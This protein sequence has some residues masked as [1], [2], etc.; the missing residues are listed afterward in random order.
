[1][2]ERFLVTS[3]FGFDSSAVGLWWSLATGGTIV[4]P[5]DDE[6]H[7]VD[8]LLATIEARDVSHLLM[9]PSL[10]EALMHRSPDRMGGVRVAIVAGE[11]CPASLVRRHHEVLPGVDLVNEYGPTEATVWSTAHRVRP[12]DDPVPIGRPIPGTTVRVAGEHG[13]ALPH[14]VVGE[15]LVSGPGVTA[16][17]VGDAAAT[18]AAFV[19]LDEQRWYRTGD[20]AIVSDGNVRFVGRVD[21]Q[22]N[23]GGV[24]VEPAEI[25]N[26]LR[27]VTTIDDAIVVA[28]GRPARLVAHVVA[29]DGADVDEAT[30]RAVLGERLAPGAVP[31]R[32]IGH[33]RLPRTPNGK[34]D[35]AAAARLAIPGRVPDAMGEVVDPSQLPEP[36]ASVIWAWNEVFDVAVGPNTDF[37]AIGGDSLSAVMLVT[38]LG[39]RLERDVAVATVVRGRTPLGMADLLDDPDR[40]ASSVV[41][42][43]WFRR[44]PGEDGPV[45]VM[46]PSWDDVFGYQQL[47]RAMPDEVD[48]VAFG[49]DDRRS[50]T[51]V[52]RYV[53]LV[54]S[55]L[56]ELRS[57]RPI[58]VVG[59]SI[60]GVVAMELAAQLEHR[61]DGVVAVGLVDTFF[62]GEERHLW[63]NRWWKYRS[64]VTPRALPEWRTEIGKVVRSRLQRLRGRFRS[65]H[66]TSV[67]PGDAAGDAGAADGVD[68]AEVA[69][70]GAI[71]ADAFAHEPSR[72]DTPVVF[73]AAS[74]T[75]PA[76]THR[77]WQTVADDLTVVPVQGRHRGFESVMG[78]ERVGRL[79]DGLRPY[80]RR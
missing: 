15:L 7:D 56:D 32:V 48:V 64:L 9:V 62:P 73:F 31:Q 30:V 59:W 55:E 27:S 10:Y 29:V 43:V 35:R 2:P 38:E 22:L 37:F 34:L 44:G 12:T 66:P 65:D 3:S 23:L 77:R 69:M 14:G 70:I 54:L 72:V 68:R 25:E 16:G 42:V 57:D 52:E 40:G 28:A 18:A 39:T 17:Y 1:P 49:L 8:A 5:T 45:V 33:D 78:A 41:Q 58:I 67:P 20:L 47:A 75:N 6:V 24:R 71:P 4:L 21:D 46:T 74:G 79:V 76:R 51:T 26:A 80:L 11:A 61:G 19:D 36:L 63:S 60:G 13:R 53:D 50:V